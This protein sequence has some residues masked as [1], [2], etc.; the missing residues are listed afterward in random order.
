MM[1]WLPWILLAVYR[2]VRGGW[3]APASLVLATALV[4]VTGHLD[5]AALVLLVSGLFALW[6]LW[7]ISR[8]PSLRRLARRAVVALTLGWGLGFLLGSPS[9]LPVVEYLKSGHRMAVRFEGKQERPPVGLAALPEVVFPDVYGSSVAGSFPLLPSK[10]ETNQQESAAAAYVGVLA[11]LV[12]APLAWC[13][14]RHR[15]LNVFFVLLAVFGL[16]WCLDVP[17]I[18]DLMSAPGANMLSYNRLV[19]ATAFAILALTAIG[20]DV[21]IQRRFQWRPVCWLPAALLAGLGVWCLCEAALIPPQLPAQIKAFTHPA[22][23]WLWIKDA[24]DV[25]SAQAWF[26]LHYKISA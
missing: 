4:L 24:G 18:T 12:A 25:S 2:T 9:I 14:R 17:M 20:L 13:S 26:S 6:C 21:L 19:F 15:S 1:G 10:G 7:E 22:M 8:A 5:A 3:K 16:S 11:T 23:L